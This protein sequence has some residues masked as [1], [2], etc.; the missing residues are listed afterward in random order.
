MSEIIGK[1]NNR[2]VRF[3]K[4]LDGMIE[5]IER[6]TKKDHPPLCGEFYLTDAEL[7]KRLKVE[8][9]TLQEYRTKGKIP[10]YKLGG[11][12]LYAESDIQKLMT[13]NYN[14]AFE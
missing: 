9:R 3:F 12:I 1:E 7:S 2:I 6:L 13:Q 5:N 14:R 8:R 10:Y 11:K 4:S